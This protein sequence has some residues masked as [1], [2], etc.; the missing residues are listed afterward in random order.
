MEDRGPDVRWIPVVGCCRTRDTGPK[1][2]LET[3]L[4]KVQSDGTWG[5]GRHCHWSLETEYRRMELDVGSEREW[6]VWTSNSAEG[7]R[8]RG[9]VESILVMGNLPSTSGDSI[10]ENGLSVYRSR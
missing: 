8:S 9:R 4:G 2:V 1:E 6:E 10:D 7:P 5:Q 3:E